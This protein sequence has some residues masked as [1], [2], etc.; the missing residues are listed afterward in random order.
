VSQDGLLP[1]SQFYGWFGADRQSCIVY[2]GLFYQQEILKMVLRKSGEAAIMGK[3]Q[4]GG[5]MFNQSVTLPNGIAMPVLGWGTWFIKDSR[6]AEA[7]RQAVAIG[8]R[9]IDTAQGYRNERGVGE[10]VRICGVPRD[11]LFITSKV[12]AEHKSYEAAAESIDQSLKTMGLEYLDL[13]LIHSPQPWVDVNQS[14]N[15]YLAENRQVWKALEDALVAGKVRAIGISNFLESDIEN[16]QQTAAVKPMVNQILCHIGNTP[17]DLIMYCQ[18]HGMVLEAYSPIAHGEALK[19]PATGEMAQ[20]YGVTIPQLCIRYCLQLGM[21]VLP[22]TENPD[23]MRE[24]TMI[25]F[26]ISDADMAVLKTMER[27]KDY[28][29]HS[30]IP[31]FGGKKPR[32]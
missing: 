26:V 24:N 6:V 14:D 3:I 7:L 17:T 12:A 4:K 31:V 25:D 15:R 19:N 13:M 18:K 11:K 9:H 32:T 22:K 23:H 28:G 21:V 16:L 10:G 27:I 30:Y 29:E 1:V 8:Y 2:D 20:K 5:T